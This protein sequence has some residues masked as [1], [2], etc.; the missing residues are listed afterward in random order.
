MKWI[1][2]LF[3]VFVIM[4]S[5]KSQKINDFSTSSITYTAQSR[6]VYLSVWVENQK[7]WV[8]KGRNEKPYEVVLTAQ[9]MKELESIFSAMNLEKVPS[10]KAPTAKRLYDGA[11]IANL[12]I[13]D[14]GKAYI[15]KSFDHGFPPKDIEKIVTL[16]VSYSEK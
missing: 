13:S 15:S 1:S 9:E 16:L 8:I 14:G 5:C 12:A 11:A 4:S 3:F 6:G 2:Q 10:L 7:V